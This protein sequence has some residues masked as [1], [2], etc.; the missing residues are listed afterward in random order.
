MCLRA[1]FLLQPSSQLLNLTPKRCPDMI[2]VLNPVSLG[3]QPATS[4]SQF[5]PA[6]TTLCKENTKCCFS[7]IGY[8]ALRFVMKKKI[9]GIDCQQPLLLLY[10][11][12]VLCCQRF[13][14]PKHDTPQLLAKAC[15]PYTVPTCHFSTPSSWSDSDMMKLSLEAPQRQNIKVYFH[16]SAWAPAS[17]KDS[18]AAGTG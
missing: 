3:I 4:Q 12:A 15:W 11:S 9:H 2:T 14:Y 10:V 1:R 17:N 16:N 13:C 8:F 6:E 5:K 7:I 18:A